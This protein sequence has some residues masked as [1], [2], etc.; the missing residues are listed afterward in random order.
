[1]PELLSAGYW[2]AHSRQNWFLPKHRNEGIEITFV[3]NGIVPF[4][5]DGKQYRLEPNAL[6]VTRPWQVHQVGFSGMPANK[7]IWIIID[8]GVRSPNQ[9]W[10]WPDWVILDEPL[11]RELTRYIR[12]NET[13][14]WLSARSM[15][16][17][18][19]EIAQTVEN[20]NADPMTYGLLKIKLNELLLSL[21]RY[22]LSMDIALSSTY[23]SNAR[24]V[25][26]FLK[27]LEEN[28]SFPWT[29]EQMAKQCGVGATSL[30]TY[31]K[32]L[33]NQTPLRY[34]K[35]LRIAKAKRLLSRPDCTD[36]ILE[37]ALECG[38]SSSQYF[39]VEFQKACGL[40][41][42]GYRDNPSMRPEKKAPLYRR[43]K[44]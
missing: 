42:T 12:E 37:I 43:A 36:S 9:E 5:V 33:T 17:C 3:E 16:D 28:L 22:Y 44:R 18:F 41:P 7:L 25:K 34:L 20:P 1:M 4:S 14:V 31:C 11:Q 21:L 26:L 10:S 30:S 8:V 19:H 23:T 35:E 29:I 27:Q 6:T 13:P 32:E 15:R 39:A 24:A 2:S 40:T 38:F